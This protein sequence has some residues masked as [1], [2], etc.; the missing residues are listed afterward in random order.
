M[1]IAVFFIGQN[2]LHIANNL[3]TF[4]S[5]LPH[6][7]GTHLTTAAAHL[8]NILGPGSGGACL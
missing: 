3:I 7:S 2:S 6:V 1:G 5:F 4:D 8:E